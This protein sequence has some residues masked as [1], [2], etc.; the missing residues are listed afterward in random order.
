MGLTGSI[1]SGKSSVGRLLAE[2]GALL[3]DADALARDATKDPA[4][5]RRVSDELGVHL[6]REGSLDRAAVAALVFADEGALAKLNAIVHPWVGARRLE[7]QAEALAAAQPP[8]LI[9]HDVPL[10]FE[11]GLDAAVDTTVVVTAPLEVRVKR[12]E[13][14]SSMSEEDVRA[15]DSAQMPQ[16]EKARRAEF[17]VDN[18]GSQAAL[19]EEVARLWEELLVRRATLN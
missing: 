5:L 15:R 1:G 8:P 14:R 18:S 13:A 12:L 7:L 2:W 17:L 10:L 11:T 16:E 9:V 4:V 3:I 19:Q 6:V